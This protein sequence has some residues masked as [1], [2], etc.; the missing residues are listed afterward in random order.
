MN[1]LMVGWCLLL[2]VLTAHTQSETE[3]APA[4]EIEVLQLA[5]AE[6]IANHLRLEYG[7]AKAVYLTRL[8]QQLSQSF[9]STEQLQQQ[10]QQALQAEVTEPQAFT[11]INTHALMAQS[12][13]QYTNGMTLNRWRQIDL[14]AP[15]PQQ[16]PVDAPISPTTF[17]AWLTL[18]RSWSNMLQGDKGPQ[19]AKWLPWIDAPADAETAATETT[20]ATPADSAYPLILATLN[21]DQPMNVADFN[22]LLAQ[23]LS[24][25]PLSVALLRQ[26]WHRG[27]QQLLALAYDWIELYQ[28]IELSPA[29]MTAE[30]QQQMGALIQQT[31]AFWQA[32]QS[33]VDGLDTQLFAVVD[34]LLSELPNKFKNPDHFNLSLNQQ[35]FSLLTHIN[36]PAV[37]FDHPL[38]DDIQ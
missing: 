30:E 22:T 5:D 33:Q 32:N 29:L 17:Q 14:P 24:L 11:H 2:W 31:A 35:L 1:Q 6:A 21:P 19:V 7:V 16:H 38:R 4:P 12:L 37:Y 8:A 20:D 26:D 10:W 13:I 34:T 15:D 28:L 9:A 36:N 18:N 27:Q 23:P 25:D 3:S